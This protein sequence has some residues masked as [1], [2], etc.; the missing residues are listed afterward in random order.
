MHEPTLQGGTPIV[1]VKSM[2]NLSM[3]EG[4]SETQGQADQ[5]RTDMSPDLVR[6]STVYSQ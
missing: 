3:Q 5:G 6:G 1:A 2:P 4:E